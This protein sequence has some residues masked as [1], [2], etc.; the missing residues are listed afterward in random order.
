[1]SQSI[2]A[3]G[4]D[5]R[6]TTGM[7]FATTAAKTSNTNDAE[8]TNGGRRPREDMNAKTNEPMKKLETCAACGKANG[9]D[10]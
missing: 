3:G 5:S 7:N 4:V 8:K 6:Q 9:G 2:S 1:M 10:A